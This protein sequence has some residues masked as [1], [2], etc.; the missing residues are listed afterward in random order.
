VITGASVPACQAS[1]RT[2]L[3]HA[4]RRSRAWVGVAVSGRA[5]ERIDVP[6]QITLR[7]TRRWKN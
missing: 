4:E 5:D 3:D 7:L 2:E 6:C 1:I